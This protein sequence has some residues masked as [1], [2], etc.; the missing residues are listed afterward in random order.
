MNEQISGVP[1]I[2]RVGVEVAFDYDVFVVAH[3]SKEAIQRAEAYDMW[4]DHNEFSCFSHTKEVD[5]ANLLWKHSALPKSSPQALRP[6]HLKEHVAVGKDTDLSF[7][8]MTVRKAA[9]AITALTK[10]S[11]PIGETD[12]K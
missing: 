4:D 5:S 6:Y 2:F 1:K 3:S 7:E 11:M 9:L 12:S 10:P 8:D